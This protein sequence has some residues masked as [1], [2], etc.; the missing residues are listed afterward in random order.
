MFVFFFEISNI[1]SP[2]FLLLSPSNGSLVAVFFNFVSQKLFDERG[3]PRYRIIVEGANLFFTQAARLRLEQAGVVLFK[4]FYFL[5]LLLFPF[6]Y[7][8]VRTPVPT[9]VV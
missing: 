9:K 3:V 7:G 4:V 2:C 5:F 1:S 6:I 8:Y